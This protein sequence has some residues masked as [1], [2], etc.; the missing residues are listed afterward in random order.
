LIKYAVDCNSSAN[1]DCIKEIVIWNRT[2]SKVAS[3]IVVPP[4][5]LTSAMAQDSRNLCDRVT[6]I[7][8]S[9][10]Q[11]VV[12]I[13]RRILIALLL[14]GGV[15]SLVPSFG[16]SSYGFA[17][18]EMVVDDEISQIEVEYVTQV[19]ALETR[20]ANRYDQTAREIDL[21]TI[22]RDNEIRQLELAYENRIR[23][24][25]TERE[26]LE[27]EQWNEINRLSMERDNEIR[28]LEIANNN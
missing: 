24:L 25:E 27:R 2:S 12:S 17:P 15:L 4:S 23:E 28:Q 10:E 26:T 18:F 6:H 5:P 11:I 13:E 19:R 1:K 20:N 21:L 9:D 8:N 22:E 14:I 16:D 3:F 7:L